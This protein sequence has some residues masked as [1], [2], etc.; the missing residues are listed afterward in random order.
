M[1]KHAV[2]GFYF[3]KQQRAEREKNRDIIP[4]R[5]NRENRNKC[6][7]A[8][9]RWSLWPIPVSGRSLFTLLLPPRLTSSWPFILFVVHFSRVAL[10][11]ATVSQ[12][13]ASSRGKKKRV[14]QPIAENRRNWQ[15][16]YYARPI[17]ANALIARWRVAKVWAPAIV[18]RAT[19]SFMYYVVFVINN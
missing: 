12:H 7:G 4:R 18:L 9:S 2:F 6:V 17:R 19:Y 14:V 15:L 13:A 10:A 1:K 3:Y 16:K 11:H 8:F 5:R